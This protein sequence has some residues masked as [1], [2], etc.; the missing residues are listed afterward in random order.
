MTHMGG[1]RERIFAEKVE[2]GLRERK[3]LKV[4]VTIWKDGSSDAISFLFK[5]C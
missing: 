2:T 4:S 5:C 3:D 1:G